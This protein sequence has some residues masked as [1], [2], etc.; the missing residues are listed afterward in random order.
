[1]LTGND[2]TST[3]G[4]NNTEAITLATIIDCVQPPRATGPASHQGNLRLN[5]VR[6]DRGERSSGSRH[7]SHVM[8]AIAKI[9]AMDPDELVPQGAM[10]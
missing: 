4:K 10:S 6:A 2:M 7:K 5:L 8:S 3:A 9:Y 1:M